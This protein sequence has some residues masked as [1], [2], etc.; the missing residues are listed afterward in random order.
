MAQA[1]D[2]NISKL[3]QMFPKVEGDVIAILLNDCEN[4]GMGFAPRLF[5]FSQALCEA[6]A[7]Y[8]RSLFCQSLSMYTCVCHEVALAMQVQYINLLQGVKLLSALYIYV[9]V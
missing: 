9:Y 8:K 3:Q 5:S 4:D 6:L 1:T 7:S 2:A